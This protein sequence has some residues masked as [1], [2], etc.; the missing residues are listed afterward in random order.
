MLKE[1]KKLQHEGLNG[2]IYTR[3]ICIVICDFCGKEFEKCSKRRLKDTSD[4]CSIL[5]QSNAYK[6]GTILCEKKQKKTEETC[7][8]RYGRKSGFD[9]EK[10]KQTML[11]KHGVEN[12]YM[13]PSVR[14]KSIAVKKCLFKEGKIKS[15]FL[16]PEVREKANKT[17]LERYGKLGPVHPLKGLDNPMHRE[18]VKEKLKKTNLEK[19]GVNCNLMLPE[20][21]AK[22]A[23]SETHKK[24]HETMKKKC[25]YKNMTRP[26]TIVKKHLLSMFEFNDIVYQQF[27]EHW[28]I[29]F[30]VKSIGAYI[31]VDGLYWHGLDRPIEEIM[32]CKTSRDKVILK[33]IETD[34]RQNEWFKKNGLKL[35]RVREDDINMGN[36]VEFD[37]FLKNLICQE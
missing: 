11:L 15:P 26:E 35:F 21:K 31:Q 24:R 23:L 10:A 7:L 1:V 25:A 34:A 3:T 29:D 5:H 12:G 9:S 19:F 32:E 20:V 8:K 37:V 36:F 30:Y 4:F 28:P 22:L 2:Q 13:I 27:T 14:E 18:E 16:R 17:Y 6:K 33:K